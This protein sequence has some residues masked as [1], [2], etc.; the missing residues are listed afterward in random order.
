MV[1]SVGGKKHNMDKTNNNNVSSFLTLVK[2]MNIVEALII[3]MF[4]V[5]Q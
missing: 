3:V 1:L 5:I 2:F 4:S